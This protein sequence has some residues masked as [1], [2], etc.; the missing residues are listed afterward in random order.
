MIFGSN[1][2]FAHLFLFFLRLD[3]LV[4]T[5]NNPIPSLRTAR[6]GITIHRQ[7][8]ECRGFATSGVIAILS[9]LLY[10]FHS[11]RSI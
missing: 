10:T 11:T 2:L 1:E 5:I 8:R 7:K 3:K 6:K 9:K 4:L